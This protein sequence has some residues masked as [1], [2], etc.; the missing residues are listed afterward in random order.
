MID[1]DKVFFLEYAKDLCKIGRETNL[2]E[3]RKE[4]KKSHEPCLLDTWIRPH[5]LGLNTCFETSTG[6]INFTHV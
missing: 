6:P 1:C 3:R 5:G 2:N 4:A